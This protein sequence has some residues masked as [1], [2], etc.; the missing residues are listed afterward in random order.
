MTNSCLKQGRGQEQERSVRTA[1]EF[2]LLPIF[3]GFYFTANGRGIGLASP[4]GMTG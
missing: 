1:S 3:A 4:L 2:I